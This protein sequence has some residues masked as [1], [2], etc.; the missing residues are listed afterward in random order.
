MGAEDGTRE[1]GIDLTEGGVRRE[2]HVQ[3]GGVAQQARRQRDAAG[4]GRRIAR[5]R[6]L[7]AAQPHP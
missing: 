4:V 2:A 7:D 1:G 5:H 3:K 6:E